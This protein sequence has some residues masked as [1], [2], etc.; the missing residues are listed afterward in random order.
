MTGYL[1]EE[2]QLLSNYGYPHMTQ[3]HDSTGGEQEPRPLALHVR[4]RRQWYAKRPL[5][6]KEL[7]DLSGLDER[8]VR[9]YETSRSLYP[10]IEA[11]IRLAR[12]LRVAVEE[13]VAPDTLDHIVAEVE[14]RRATMGLCDR[15]T[16]A[17]W[18]RAR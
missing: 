8:R 1:T 9:A 12:A 10:E 16:D 3:L 2:H 17:D 6:Q 14:A 18:C 7:A 11:L 13:L 4:R 15:S 5:T